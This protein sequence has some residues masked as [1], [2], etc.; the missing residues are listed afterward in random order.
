MYT[1]DDLNGETS[2]SATFM[3][4]AFTIARAGWFSSLSIMSDAP[5]PYGVAAGMQL[6]GASAYLDGTLTSLTPDGLGVRWRTASVSA[7][8]P[9]AASNAVVV[10]TTALQAGAAFASG[11]IADSCP[12]ACYAIVKFN[13]TA[14]DGPVYYQ[15]YV[16]PYATASA[17]NF[18]GP[19]V[20]VNSSGFI[21]SF[22]I[23]SAPWVPM[24]QA[25]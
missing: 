7:P 22:T 10:R 16:T 20:A 6:N 23:W 3:S 17:P 8:V 19:T 9:L 4:T 2:T 14:R 15:N 12:G 13:V 21:T 24:I 11:V 25:R 5:T 1:N 18:Y